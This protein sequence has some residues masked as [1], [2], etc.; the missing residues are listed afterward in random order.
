MVR[1]RLGALMIVCIAGC[2]PHERS[3]EPSAPCPT[4][5]VEIGDDGPG[6]LGVAKECM[7]ITEVTTAAY[8]A[9]VQAGVCTPAIVGTGK[10]CNLTRASQGEHPIN[11]ASWEQA[12][13]YCGWL[14]KRLPD[15]PEWIWAA[16][17]G[18]AATP[19]PWGRTPPDVT[20]AC[21]ARTAP[22]TCPVGIYP[23]GASPAGIVDLIGNVAEWTRGYTGRGRAGAAR[24]LLRGGSHE[25]T[26]YRQPIDERVAD[27]ARDEPTE[28]ATPTSGMRCVVALHTP[29]QEVD[30]GAW[31]PVVPTPG[32]LPPILAARPTMTRPTR[33]LAN[34]GVLDRN[35]D[36]AVWWALGDSATP[37]T[38]AAAATLGLKDHVQ[39]SVK[40]EAL[41]SFVARRWIGDMVLMTNNSSYDLK[42]VALEPATFKLRWQV[43]LG[44]AG[45]S[46]EQVVTP[47]TLVVLSTGDTSSALIGH[48]LD[49]GREVWR[50]RG[51]TA[52]AGFTHVKR[53]WSD[54]ERVFVVGDAGV[55]AFDANTGAKLWG[56]LVIGESCGVATAPGVL[57]VEDA[58]GLR[59]ID[60]GSGAMVRR[61]GALGACAWALDAW[62]GRSPPGAI[63][64]DRL[65]AFDTP[66]VRADVPD[67]GSTLRAFD[68]ATGAE[69]WR[70]PRIGREL[71]RADQDAVFVRDDETL[72]AIDAAN[73]VTRAEVSLGTS[74]FDVAVQPG[75]GEAGP[76]VV[77]DTSDTGRWILGRKPEPT[78]PESFVIRGR[79]I[80]DEGLRKWQAGDV[81]VLVHGKLVRTG[82]DGRFEARGRAVGAVS[83]KLGTT[84]GPHERGGSRVRFEDRPVILD[85]SGK[86]VV[87]D[88]DLT[89]WA[90]Y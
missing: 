23:Q 40:P 53:L 87:D 49:S 78:P 45:R 56:G 16:Q 61:I 83:I 4:G 90:M 20:R 66:S 33:P 17:G 71:L 76:L 37:L 14:G 72:V 44:N 75:G 24:G 22:G 39:M 13:T 57:V 36:V 89:E 25:D 58:A 2:A 79:L 12:Q 34:L 27:S 8:G 18:A 69:V 10:D 3:Q 30:A 84:S 85:G 9:C 55:A 48:A 11:C 80:P 32:G 26:V 47:R 60:P 15:D 35:E 50:V 54:D 77:V 62:D 42:L 28:A 6:L 59:V 82:K 46:Y 52:D 67:R 43:A 21:W 51:G 1:P 74:Y 63:A 38:P 86:Y 70:R 88:I 29:V 81:P 64:G 68:L 5:M 41:R 65:I 73:G 31:T 7:D 19:F